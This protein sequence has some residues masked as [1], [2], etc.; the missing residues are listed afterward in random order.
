MKKSSRRRFLQDSLRLAGSGMV[1]SP[2][3]SFTAKEGIMENRNNS[4]YTPGY[5]KLHQSG[6]L[7]RRVKVL[8]AFYE[9]CTLCPRD[10]RINRIRGELGKCRAGAELK[11]SSAFPHFGEERPLVGKNGSGT[12]FFS[13][14]GLQCIYCQNYTISFEGEGIEISEQRAAESMLKLQKLGCHNINLVTPT[15]FIP[16]IVSAL[17]KAVPLGLKLP[18]VYNT[19]GFDRPEVLQLLDGIVDIYLP[20]FKYWEAA[21]AAQYS[22]EA[23]SYPFYAR[24]AFKEIHR[25]VGDLETDRRGIAQKGLMV[26]HLVLPNRIAGSREILN[27]IARDLSLNTYVNIMRQYRPEYKARQY[28]DIDRRI[29]SK[30]YQEALS[31]AKEFGLTRLDR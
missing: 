19:S 13:F 7:S 16:G 20:D 10:C 1:F 3:V 21:N 4:E 27:F 26:R 28:P 8:K 12:I 2:L 15:H 24:L 5:L 23:Y 30:E 22:S 17:E 9:E 31:W 18:I 14:C 6:E 25:Q 11:V 29:S